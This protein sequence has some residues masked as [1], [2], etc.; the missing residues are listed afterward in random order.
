MACRLPRRPNSTTARRAAAARFSGPHHAAAGESRTRIR[1]LGSTGGWTV[2]G[3]SVCLAPTEVRPG[4]LTVTTI[5]ASDRPSAAAGPSAGCDLFRPPASRSEAI[6]EVQPPHRR[7]GL[8]PR[9]IV[10]A[11]F[12]FHDKRPC[13]CCCC[14]M[15]TPPPPPPPP[16]PADV[17]N[18][19]PARRSAEAPPR[20]RSFARTGPFISGVL[21]R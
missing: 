19:R 7:P 20:G 1:R 13:R 14:S 12:K 11:P 6:G 9:H 15:L 18:A 8:P 5:T 2:V 16:S 3:R 17:A 4:T 21:G 10:P